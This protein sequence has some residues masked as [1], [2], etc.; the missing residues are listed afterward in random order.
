MATTKGAKTLQMLYSGER[1]RKVDHSYKH[2]F[3]PP[4]DITG[5]G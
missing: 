5:H 2:L 1:V 3:T 4:L